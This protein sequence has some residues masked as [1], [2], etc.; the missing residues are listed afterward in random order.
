[1]LSVLA[2]A[3]AAPAA[4]AAEPAI[5][6]LGGSIGGGSAAAFEGSPATPR[7]IIGTTPPR[8]PYMAPNG[9][10]NIHADAFQTDSY[11][12]PG[13]LG[14]G[15]TV[16]STLKVADCGSVMFDSRG[17]IVTICVGILAPTLELLDPVTLDRLD[18]MPLP[19]RD[20]T[21]VARLFNDFAGGGYFYLDE[22]DR[23]VFS[24]N[25][26]H[27]LT[28][29]IDG[30]RLVIDRDMDLSGTVQQG[31]KLYSALPDW[32]GRLWFITARGLAGTVDPAGEV[33]AI[34]TGEQVANSFAIDDDGGVYVVT[35]KHLYRLAAAADGTPRVVWKER[36]RN[37]GIAKPGQV[38]AGSGTTPTIMDG[39][40]VAITDNADPMNVV[41]YKRGANVRGSRVVCEQ[42]V[43]AK[44]ASATDNSL[45]AARNSLVVENN[46]GYSGPGAVGSGASTRPGIERVDIRKD[47][48]GCRT[49]W[50]SRE[51]APTVVPKLSLATGLIYAYTK[52]PR[53][54]RTDAWYLTALDFCTGAKRWSRL[55]G[56]GLGFNNNYAPVTL[57]PD[58][59]AYVGVLGGLVRFADS[60]PPTGPPAGSRAGCSPKP[61]LTLRARRVTLRSGGCGVRARIGGGDRGLVRRVRFGAGRRAVTDR[62]RPFAKT[63]RS[64]SRTVRAAVR[65]QSGKLVKLRARAGACR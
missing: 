11:T 27:I 9:R 29:R 26:R 23:A 50:K 63:L 43:F 10:S 19:L 44:G 49:V 16:N 38:G 65:L 35:D 53:A 41:V 3:V 14:R 5:P 4:G 32:S 60:T 45:V 47:G 24:T 13:P 55:S 57:G 25:N 52:P 61:R 30:D 18:S 6:I 59:A 15:T 37:S 17:R 28:V 33:K 2:C 58:G 64:R 7:R 34:A 8:H 48:K 22:R 54:D 12:G 21:G 42:P 20:L 31:D 62:R 46:Y 36:Y 56:M 1:L 51:V 39:G 40:R